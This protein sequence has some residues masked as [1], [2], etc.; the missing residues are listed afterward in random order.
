[1][2][3][4]AVLLPVLKFLYQNEKHGCI[5]F[6]VHSTVSSQCIKIH[7][8]IC[9]HCELALCCAPMGLIALQCLV[10]A[11]GPGCCHDG[12]G[13]G[14]ATVPAVLGCMGLVGCRLDVSEVG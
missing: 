8:R 10:G 5:F 14:E 9:H 12:M 11:E 3:F 2:I 13:Q 1:M 4:L 7:E 6:S